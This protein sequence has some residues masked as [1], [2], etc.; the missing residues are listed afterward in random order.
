MDK[1]HIVKTFQE[2][3]EKDEV[4]TDRDVLEK[5]FEDETPNLRGCTGLV[6]KPKSIKKI[7]KIMKIAFNER[8]PVVPRGAGTGLAGGAVPSAN[9]IVLSLE[10]MNKILE[11]D[12][13]NWMA[14]VE[15]GVITQNISN[16]SKEFG[17]FYPPDPA[18]LDACTIGGNIATGAGGARTVKYG[19]TKDY[20][21]GLTVV[22]PDGTILKTGGKFLKNST[23]YNLTGLFVRSEGTL[24]IITEAIVR[25]LPMPVFSID[26]LIPY[27]TLN[28]ALKTA[29]NL[30]VLPAALEFMEKEAIKSAERFLDKTFVFGDAEVHLLIEFDG[31]KR[32]LDS[33]IERVGEIAMKHNAIDVMIADT[34]N[35]RERIWEARRNISKALKSEGKIASQDVVIPRSNIPIF[36]EK[37]N[38]IKQKYNVKIVCFGH[39][40][41]GNIHVN[42]IKASES[43]KERLN[44][45]LKDVYKLALSLNGTISGE[46]GIGLVK[47]P[48]IDMALPSANISLMRKIKRAVD[49]YNIM[50]PNKIFNL[51]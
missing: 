4:I 31:E 5:Y 37:L 13:K 34:K 38:R 21:Y 46:H 20:I 6:L 14:V 47:K 9:D 12:R 16:A 30:P 11:I 42:I 33:I 44:F 26:L 3:L 2:F 24:G 32:S 15:P 40:G 50:N 49:P 25:L 36:L 19:T 48:Y 10:S 29:F 22:L 45:I 51:Q 17:L 41:D 43:I 28:D 27:K 7:S 39:L 1:S 23:G 8:I 18:S 35:T